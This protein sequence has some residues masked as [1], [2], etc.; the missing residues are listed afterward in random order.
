[1]ERHLSKRKIHISQEEFTLVND[2]APFFGKYESPNTY[3]VARW[4]RSYE[5][6]GY[7]VSESDAVIA[8]LNQHDGVSNPDE[9]EMPDPSE[10]NY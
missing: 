10:D 2:S 9:W 6:R 8:L 1:M 5:P 3:Y 7:G 4:E